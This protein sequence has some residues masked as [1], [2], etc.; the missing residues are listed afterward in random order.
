MGASTFDSQGRR[1]SAADLLSSANVQFL[2]V[3]TFASVRRVLFNVSDAT[4]RASGVE[5]TD[6]TSG[7]Q[8][9]Y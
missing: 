8:L 3:V 2:T 9:A 4:P 6:S 5:Y 7:T 1:H